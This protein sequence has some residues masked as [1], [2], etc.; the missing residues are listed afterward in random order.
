MSS[1]N[2]ELFCLFG[3]GV[4]LTLVIGFYCVI[5][6]RNLVRALIGMEV[7]TKGVTLLLILCGYLANRM[8]L[9]QTLA[10]TLII[11]E[12][13]VIVVAISVF[14]GIFRRTRSVNSTDVQNLKG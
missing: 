7:L 10:I 11:V 2:M 12:V 8:A 9:A 4:L 14:L 3:L 13:A 1:A 5:R 6:T